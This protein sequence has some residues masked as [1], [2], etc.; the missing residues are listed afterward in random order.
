MKLIETAYVNALLADAS[1]RSLIRGMTTEQLTVELRDRLTETQANYLAANFTVVTSNQSANGGFDS[2]VWQIKAGSA[3]AGPNNENAGRIFLSMRGTQEGQDI[4]DD[5]TLATKGIPYQQIADMVNWWLKNT[6]AVTNTQG[7]WG[8]TPITGSQPD[9]QNMIAPCGRCKRPAGRYDL[10]NGHSAT[11]GRRRRPRCGPAARLPRRSAPVGL[12]PAHDVVGGAQGAGAAGHFHAALEQRQRRDAADVEACR[13]ILMV[14]GVDL[15]HPHPRLQLGGGLL[16]GR[17]HHAA[18][19][20]PRRPEVHQHRDLAA[21]DVAVK[22][23]F[24]QRDRRAGEQRPVAAAA[25]GLAGQVVGVDAVGGVAV[26][27]NDVQ[28]F[29]HG[30]IPLW[31]SS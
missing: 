28:R 23:G 22:G 1:Y 4:L 29:T 30:S 17:G 10:Q 9:G 19:A 20:A 26:W 13:Q 3:L 24:V 14:L 16:E 12:R 15:D 18:R 11:P 7:N 2:V 5:V 31:V 8:Q 21:A 27:T 25:V 6:A